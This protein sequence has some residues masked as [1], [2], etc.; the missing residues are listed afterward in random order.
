MNKKI[1]LIP[2]T[3]GVVR[4]WE[5][6]KISK[7]ELK[8]FFKPDDLYFIKIK[9]EKKVNKIKYYGEN[10]MDNGITHERFKKLDK[11]GN[12]RSCFF[13]VVDNIK[14]L[15]NFFEGNKD[16]SRLLSSYCN[17][18]IVKFVEIKKDGDGGVYLQFVGTNYTF[19]NGELNMNIT[20]SSDKSFFKVELDNCVVSCESVYVDVFDVPLTKNEVNFLKYK[21]KEINFNQP[22]RTNTIKDDEWEYQDCIL[23]D[24]DKKYFQRLREK[25]RKYINLQRFHKRIEDARF[26]LDE[27]EQIE[28]VVEENSLGPRAGEEKEITT[29]LGDGSLTFSDNKLKFKIIYPYTIRQPLSVFNFSKRNTKKVDLTES[30]ISLAI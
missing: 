27:W 4:V 10:V 3:P 2:T 16:I 29:D 7:L 12:E 17:E 19:F 21:V 11:W 5:E 28:I 26:L 13:G 20:L 30:G 6:N 18:N 23:E 15:R 1:G 24:G 22:Y 8:P 25:I 14:K 9:D